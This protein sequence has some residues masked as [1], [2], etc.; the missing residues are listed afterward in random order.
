MLGFVHIT[1]DLPEAHVRDV[2][3]HQLNPIYGPLLEGAVDLSEGKSHGGSPQ[4]SHRLLPDRSRG[5]TDP[6]T[7]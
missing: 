6:Q 2:G 5:G 3:V 4:G 1:Q 7:P